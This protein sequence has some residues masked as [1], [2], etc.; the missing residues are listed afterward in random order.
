MDQREYHIKKCM[1]CLISGIELTVDSWFPHKN[2]ASRGGDREDAIMAAGNINI[3]SWGEPGVLKDNPSTDG[4]FGS[5]YRTTCAKDGN[6]LMEHRD[7]PIDP[8][9][10]VEHRFI[11]NMYLS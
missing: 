9:A 11:S 2:I 7:E 10:S 4:S 1:N 3:L 6:E 5:S 8:L